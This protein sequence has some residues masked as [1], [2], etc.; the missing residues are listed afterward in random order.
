MGGGAAAR[1]RSSKKGG[2]SSR[3][4]GSKKGGSSSRKGGSKKGGSG[5][6]KGG[7]KKGGSKKGGSKAKEEAK[8][9]EVLE[10]ED[11]LK[12]ITKAAFKKYDKAGTGYLD[13]NMV[14][15]AT[16]RVCDKAEFP[17]FS[18][19]EFEDFFQRLDENNDGKVSRKEFHEFIKMAVEAGVDISGYSSSL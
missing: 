8:K 11:E 4:G 17:R 13:K 7:S 2:S 6:R 1:S 9:K 14:R 19:N 16:D 5:S 18:Q 15:I 10:D 3:R 12:R